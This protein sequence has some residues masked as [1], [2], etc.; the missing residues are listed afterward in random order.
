MIIH[1]K[2]WFPV[3]LSLRV[4]VIVVI[5][6]AVLA[7]PLARRMAKSWFPGRDVVEALITLPLV[8]PPSVTGY[9]LLI[10]IGR[11]GPIGAWLAHW[12]IT[13]IFTWWAVVLAA[14]VVAFPLMYQSAKAAFSSVDKDLENAARTLGAGEMRVFFS[15][16]LPL[17]WPGI[18]AG[19]VL[20][21]AR[22]LGE[23]GAT[24]MVAGNIPGQTQTIPLA[25]YFASE[26]GDDAT[27]MT[28]VAL[29]TIF[30][31]LVIFLVN[32]WNRGKKY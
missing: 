12:D 30:S 17:A 11:R 25:I 16:T 9:L 8:L 22:A 29:I 21:F 18:M 26:S 14:T 20:T 3:L 15:V 31:F 32:R 6:V 13:L 5:V 4:A 27:A 28:L 19:V 23:F 7:L 24:L 1:L 10:L 2:D